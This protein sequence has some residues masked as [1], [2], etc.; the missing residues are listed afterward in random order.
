[1]TSRFSF[2][3]N[4][5]RAADY[6]ELSQLDSG[7]EELSRKVAPADQSTS[8][9]SKR[10]LWMTYAVVLC[11]IINVAILIYDRADDTSLPDIQSLP[12]PNPYP[13]LEP[14]LRNIS[15]SDK[16]KPINTWPVFIGAV[17]EADAARVYAEEPPHAFT[18][19]GT[20]YPSTKHFRISKDLDSIIQFRVR[21]FAMENC[22]ISILLPDDVLNPESPFDSPLR[23]SHVEIWKLQ[24]SQLLDPDTL[25]W[26]TKPA[27]ESLLDVLAWP[28][29]STTPSVSTS[30]GCASR[31]LQTF[32]LSCRSDSQS[33]CEVDLWQGKTSGGLFGVT[34]KQSFSL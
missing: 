31:S 10:V 19:V 9:N 22:S 18:P 11:T 29:D 26:K 15:Q 23:G 13:G 4:G 5:R 21:D 17:S 32:R 8:A 1:M 16:P 33:D 28:T 2:F 14:L 20:V 24:T 34:L 6:T 30:F 27:Q 7:S 3:P 12:R 25:S